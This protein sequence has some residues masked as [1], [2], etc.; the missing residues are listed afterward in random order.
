MI[1]CSIY[2]SLPC[3]CFLGTFSKSKFSKHLVLIAHPEK[4]FMPLAIS[5]LVNA[6]GFLNG[7][8]PHVGQK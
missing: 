3:I 4:G 8:M 1:T 2:N 5:S 7:S 6:L